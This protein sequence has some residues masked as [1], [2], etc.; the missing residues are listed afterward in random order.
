MADTPA[1]DVCLNCA[2]IDYGFSNWSR[3]GTTVVCTL[4]VHPKPEFDRGWRIPSGDDDLCYATECDQFAPGGPGITA[5]VEHEDV[6]IE[7][8]TLYHWW[9]A[10]S[11]Q[12]EDERITVAGVRRLRPEGAD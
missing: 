11:S 2:L 4:G 7:N 3:E 6:V 1:C 8:E 5:D 12:R 9:L 10:E